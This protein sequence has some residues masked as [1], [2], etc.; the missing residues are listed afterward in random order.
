MTQAG[1]SG[2]TQMMRF[3]SQQHLAQLGTL[4][5]V[6]LRSRDVQAKGYFLAYLLNPDRYAHSNHRHHRRLLGQV[7][8]GTLS[9]HRPLQSK[10]SIIKLEFR[11]HFPAL[12]CCDVTDLIFLL[13][14]S[15]NPTAVSQITHHQQQSVPPPNHDP[16]R[17]PFRSLESW[18]ISFSIHTVT[19]DFIFI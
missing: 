14:L 13:V 3:N 1:G 16:N 9:K 5:W 15:M 10:F 2:I 6:V 12:E 4:E 17:S 7:V 8:P 18:F 11:R 19:R